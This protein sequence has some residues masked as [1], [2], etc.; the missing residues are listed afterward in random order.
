MQFIQ[1][2]NENEARTCRHAQF[3]G[4]VSKVTV[5]GVTM[6]GLVYAVKENMAVVPRQWTIT[7]APKT[8]PTFQPYRK[9]KYTG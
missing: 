3:A 4:R 8:M 9:R 6:S 1:T 5:G 2:N 7:I